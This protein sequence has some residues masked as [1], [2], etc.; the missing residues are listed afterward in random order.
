MILDLIK[1]LLIPILVQIIPGIILAY[2]T[3]IIQEKRRWDRGIFWGAIV[4]IILLILIITYAYSI[5][6]IRSVPKITD[7]SRETAEAKLAKKSL[8]LDVDKE[9][10]IN[11]DIEELLGKNI[12]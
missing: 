2:L 6:T 1:L 3:K 5:N 10:Y 11:K 8:Q 12:R 4:I 9:T 7:V